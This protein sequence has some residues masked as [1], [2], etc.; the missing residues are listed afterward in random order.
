MDKKLCQSCGMPIDD[1]KLFGLNEDGTKNEDYCVYCFKDGKFTTDG[2][3]EEMIEICVPHMV[4][5]G[6]EESKAREMLNNI[7]PNLKRWAKQ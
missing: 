5:G 3:M 7:L 1:E 2:T 4:K 6:L